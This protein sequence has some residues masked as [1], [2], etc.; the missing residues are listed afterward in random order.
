MEC[1]MEEKLQ[2]LTQLIYQEGIAKPNA[3][4]D[5]LISD[6][7]EK[8]KEI[9][10]KA[11]AEAESIRNQVAK[12]TEELKKNVKSELKIASDQILSALKQKITDLVVLDMIKS[13]VSNITKAEDFYKEI[14]LL[15]FKKWD[16]NDNLANLDL[17]LPESL[18][19]NLSDF[20]KNE[21]NN[22][23]AKS[24]NIAFSNKI[25]NGFVISSRESGYYLS[26]TDSDFNE[27]FKNYLKPK[28]ADLI[29]GE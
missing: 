21:L 24:M 27:L 2:E 26:F 8:A 16:E 25:P 12:Q 18:K 23:M 28:T 19:N 4:A 29:F 17:L 7:Q 22:T 1:R 13:P 6:A 3:E 14:I 9:I 15:L 11:N 5:L 10:S 20:L